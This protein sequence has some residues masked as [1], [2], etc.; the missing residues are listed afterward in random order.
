MQ[1]ISMGN[2]A[3]SQPMKGAAMTV[4][5]RRRHPRSAPKKRG[6]H[7]ST[8][9]HQRRGIDNLHEENTVI[10]R[11]HKTTGVETLPRARSRT[12]TTTLM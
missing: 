11:A 9:R 8:D 4:P 10:A 12:I 2:Q 7:E 5:M 1:A 6:D 3:N